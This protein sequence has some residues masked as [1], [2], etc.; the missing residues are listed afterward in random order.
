MCAMLLRQLLQQFGGE[1]V[2]AD[3]TGWPRTDTG[4]P[5]S[6]ARMAVLCKATTEQV[7]ASLALL[8]AAGVIVER[9]G[10]W[11]YVGWLRTQESPITKRTREFREREAASAGRAAGVPGTFPEPPEEQRNR[12]T[13]LTTTPPPAGVREDDPPPTGEL[14][15]PDPTRHVPTIGQT[16]GARLTHARELVGFLSAAAAAARSQIPRGL[17]AQLEADEVLPTREQLTA[18]AA[19]LGQPEIASW[20]LPERDQALVA[21][22]VAQHRKLALEL[23][24]LDPATPD[25]VSAHDV[26]AVYAAQEADHAAGLTL[27]EAWGR[28]LPRAAEQ[29]RREAARGNRRGC[30]FFTLRSLAGKRRTALL[31]AVD[32]D[33]RDDLAP[34]TPR[35][36]P[37]P[38]QNPDRLTTGEIPT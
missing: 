34:R 33:R 38:P 13:D 35:R 26:A 24:A 9:D 27:R 18:I 8:Q 10:A 2:D 12:G 23:G 37:A 16:I 3:G 22:I 15:A 1:H 29:A 4:A 28:V 21:D 30:E 31:A 36:G 17:Y 19:T 7:Q 11:G 25:R 14:A 6:V 5:F 32:L 20:P